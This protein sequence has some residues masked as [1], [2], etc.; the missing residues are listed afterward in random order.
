M[1]NLGIGAGG[2]DGGKRAGLIGAAGARSR[3]R[4]SDGL[5]CG[6]RANTRHEPPGVN[7]EYFGDCECGLETHRIRVTT[8]NVANCAFAIQPSEPSK[9]AAREVPGELA[10][11]FESPRKGVFPHD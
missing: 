4:G 11:C 8:L 3:Y 2:L 1:R 7:T 10:C 6:S 9:L 5:R